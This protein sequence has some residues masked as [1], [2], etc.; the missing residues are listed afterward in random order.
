MAIVGNPVETG[1][2]S[3]ISRP[4]GNITGSSFFQGE[5]AAK[6]LELM[7]DVLPNLAHAAILV[8]PDNPAAE[9]F[10]RVVG[11]IAKAL[12]VELRTLNVRSF[13][14]LTPALKFARPGLEALIVIEDGLFIPHRKRIAELTTG[15]RLPSVGFREYC[16]AGGQLAYGVDLPH[17][18][19]QAGTIVDKILKGA[20]PADLPVQQ[21]TR[22]EIVINLKTAKAI[23]LAVPPALLA[24]ADEVIE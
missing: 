4:G 11:A 9:E 22:F 8:N 2:V 1:I 14:E 24:R 20:K 16:V 13:D 5:L 12:N 15:N 10:L 19:R 21:A 7:R 6:R 3:S 17:I 18:W 23:G